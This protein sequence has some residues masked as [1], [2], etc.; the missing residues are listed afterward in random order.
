MAL[1]A[2]HRHLVQRR[3][4]YV[5]LS[6]FVATSVTIDR[7][8]DAMQSSLDTCYRDRTVRAIFEAVLIGMLLDARRVGSAKIRGG[9]DQGAEARWHEVAMREGRV[10][11]RGKH[12]DRR[13]TRGNSCHSVP[14]DSLDPASPWLPGPRASSH[15]IS[16]ELAAGRA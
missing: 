10:E 15:A 6:S 7:L 12:D 5:R 11:L 4:A 13:R 1:T 14:L 2:Q 9:E 3:V 8:G 16:A